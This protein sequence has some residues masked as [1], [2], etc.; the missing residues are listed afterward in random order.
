MAPACPDPADG[1]P[2]VAW[3]EPGPY[4]SRS[5]AA[6]PSLELGE[7]E[8]AERFLH[9]ED[10]D[11]YLAA[12]LALR[13]ELGRRAGL[14][15]AALRW[16]Q[17][18]PPRWLPAEPSDAGSQGWTW[19]ASLSHTRGAVAVAS[20][21]RGAVGVDIER[22]VELDPS[23]DWANLGLAA[24]EAARLRR[25]PLEQ[26]GAAFFDLWTLKEALSKALGLGLRAELAWFELDWPFGEVDAA[27][28]R[29]ARLLRGPS[30]GPG[31]ALG[32]FVRRPRPGL[33]LAV[34]LGSGV[35]GTLR[36]LHAPLGP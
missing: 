3:A 17:G 25:L 5:R 24:G 1:G 7:R 14:D 10:R 13:L 34:A 29:Q 8:R 2:Q 26:R 30:G 23:E 16:I 9:A 6:L 28:W 32:L 31:Q 27:G 35:P 36:E 22:H 21:P 4:L 33:S 11:S 18:P 20:A 19:Q 12:H 15:P